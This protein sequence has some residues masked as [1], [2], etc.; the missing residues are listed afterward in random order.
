MILPTS[1]CVTSKDIRSCIDRPEIS[2]AHQPATE[3]YNDF[4]QIKFDAALF[5]DSAL[6]VNKKR[7][8]FIPA[9]VFWH[10]D[11]TY[12]CGLNKHFF[13]KIIAD[14]IKRYIDSLNITH[15]F[16]GKTLEISINTLPSDFRFS[17]T[18]AI[19]FYLVG[20]SYVYY[21]GLLMEIGDCN[22]SYRLLLGDETLHGNS[23]GYPFQKIKLNKNK[24]TSTFIKNYITE[25]ADYYQFIARETVDAIVDEM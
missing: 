2:C 3:R 16:A 8:Y 11:Y 18:G 13:A 6:T 17:S 14:E 19:A 4:V 21:E 7:A 23:F 25:L 10:W 9:L 1:S 24:S 12:D 22:I 15:F 20:Y 5:A